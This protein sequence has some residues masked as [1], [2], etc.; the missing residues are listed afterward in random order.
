MIGWPRRCTKRIKTYF[1]IFVF[2]RASTNSHP[3]ELPTASQWNHVESRAVWT[4]SPIP[5]L[6]RVVTE[7][8]HGEVQHQQQTASVLWCYWQLSEKPKALVTF[9]SLRIAKRQRFAFKFTRKRFTEISTSR[10]LHKTIRRKLLCQSATLNAM[11]TCHSSPAVPFWIYPML[12]HRHFTVGVRWPV[13]VRVKQLPKVHF[14]RTRTNLKW[15]RKN[16][17]VKHIKST[18][19]S[20]D[21][22]TTSFVK[23]LYLNAASFIVDSWYSFF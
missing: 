6:S 13:N 1:L 17:P 7:T 15:L 5:N 8:L 11:T 20:D 10:C 12:S 3:I 9:R 14:W 21:F 22:L 4:A 16:S 19:Y 23:P 2:F 18:R